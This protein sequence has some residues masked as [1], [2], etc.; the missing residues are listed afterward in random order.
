M[1][2][3]G[4]VESS[5]VLISQQSFEV[6][7]NWVTFFSNSV[8]VLSIFGLLLTIFSSIYFIDKYRTLPLNVQPDII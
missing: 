3:V 5:K 2:S 6:K 1:L 7:T 8:I 4:Y